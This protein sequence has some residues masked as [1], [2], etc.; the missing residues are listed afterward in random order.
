MYYTFDCVLPHFI[1]AVNLQTNE[2]MFQLHLESWQNNNI[3]KK[4]CCNYPRLYAEAL[5]TAIHTG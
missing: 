5:R 2:D 4:N 3:G 1:F